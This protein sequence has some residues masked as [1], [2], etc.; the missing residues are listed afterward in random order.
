[1]GEARFIEKKTVQVALNDGRFRQLHGERV[2]LCV[3]TRASIPDI[4]GLVI[5][6]PMAHVEALNLERL[7]DHL[8]I[9]GGGYVGL[10]FAQ[11][12]RRFGSRVTIIQRG[13]RLLEHED[14]EVS[15]AI[16]ELMNDDGIEVL[17]QG[18][19]L[20]V[21]G[22]SGST[23]Q[24]KV[25]SA[26]TER[27]VEA[28]DILV[29]A[30]RTPNTDQFDAARA[31]IELDPRGYIRVNQKLET[32]AEGVWAMGDC[33]GSPQFTHVAHD[34]YRV[35]RSN[36][37]GGK[38]TTDGRVIPY[39]LFTDPELAHIGVKES[40][41][42]AKGLKFRVA[43]VSMAFVPRMR[44]IGQ[45]RIAPHA[46]AGLQGPETT[47]PLF[48]GEFPQNQGA[49]ENRQA[50]RLPAG[51]S[52]DESNAI[53]DRQL[54][55]KVNGSTH[56]QTDRSNFLSAGSFGTPFRLHFKN[57]RHPRKQRIGFQ[58]PNLA[59]PFGLQTLGRNVV[60]F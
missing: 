2:F 37:L 46:F 6:G 40:E 58:F 60:V 1:M 7:P 35:V 5:A 49:H 17:L 30:G 28:S 29:A 11:A 23:V 33:A 32:S 31:G 21:T 14:E 43:K 18:E 20:S 16:Q 38:R 9:I 51:A 34:D 39:C 22:R 4:P 59:R 50:P 10:E 57:V 45:I 25:R 8:V 3:G 12:M 48:R 42:D 36:L 19:L 54:E 44:A 27:S 26:G 55:L 47:N 24:L 53:R 52:S 13:L 56:D 15:I 41:A